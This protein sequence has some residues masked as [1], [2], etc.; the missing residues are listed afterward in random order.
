L[1]RLFVERTGTGAKKEGKG[2]QKEQVSEEAKEE[3]KD[4]ICIAVCY[5]EDRKLLLVASNQ[6]QPQGA[7]T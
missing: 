2:K 4:D 3:K 1:A 7:E 5:D 6:E